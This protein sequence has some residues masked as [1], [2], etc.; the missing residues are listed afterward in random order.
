MRFPARTVGGRWLAGL[1]LLFALAAPL[2]FG[3]EADPPI[4]DS[5]GM[6][7]QVAELLGRLR[8]EVA[9]RPA[10]VAA[11]L[12]YAETLHAHGLVREAAACYGEA[13]ELL[14]AG[15][16]TRLTARYLL[17]HAVRGSDPAAAA[18]T[19][20]AAVAEH[21]GYPPS[22]IVLGELQEELG[23]R[24]DAATAYRAAL[25]LDPGSALALF[26]L[27]SLQLAG[28]DPRETISLLERALALAPDAGAVRSALAQAW[29]R[30]GDRDRARE[31]LQAGEGRPERGLP[32]I[33]DPIHFRM[34]ERDISSPRLLERARVARADGRLGDAESLYRDLT[35]IR[36]RDAGMLAEFGA[37][38]D[39]RGRPGEAEPLYRD[40]VALEPRQALARFGL[41]VLRA[42]EG[43]LP[44]AEYEFSESLESRPDEPQT[45]AALGDVLLRQRR[46]EAALAALER[47]RQL[48][49]RDGPSRVL[50]AV[51]LAELGRFEEAWTA[52]HEAQALG[53][54]VPE[55]FL[56]A[57]RA[58]HPEPGR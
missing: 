11:W 24:G 55:G 47:A 14:P 6:E 10:E 27:G 31:V 12:E 17:A 52:I 32:A 49:P 46:F 57:L 33:E 8:E 30:A 18:D 21:P 9:R 22:L 43:D 50:A 25:D 4:P 41:G 28:G 26:R 39:Q 13:L 15:D 5:R 23:D 2:A 29:N 7:P 53:A 56:T 58:K 51:A 44:A 48:D 54:E 19:L 38:L 37:V 20:A 1:G 16:V 35:R 42:R 34:S 36:P 40:A 45:H 3:Q